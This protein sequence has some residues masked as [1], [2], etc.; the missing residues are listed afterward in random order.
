MTTPAAWWP[1]CWP[2]E[3]PVACRPARST[4]AA[5]ARPAGACPGRSCRDWPATSPTGSGIAPPRPGP[6]A[7]PRPHGEPALDPDLVLPRVAKIVLLEESLIGAELEAVE[8]DLAS[9]GGERGP[10]YPADALV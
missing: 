2:G 7:A 6:S 8:P 4:S 5:T 3:S 1:A 9:I 10:A